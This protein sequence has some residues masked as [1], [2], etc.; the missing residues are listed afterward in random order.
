MYREKLWWKR[1]RSRELYPNASSKDAHVPPNLLV[2]NC[3]CGRPAWVFQSRHPDT[4]ICFFY[5]C[6]SFN[7][8]SF[9]LLCFYSL[10]DVY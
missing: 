4:T 2:P 10:K 9:S 8:G 6:N 1:G 7:I 3:E 5:A